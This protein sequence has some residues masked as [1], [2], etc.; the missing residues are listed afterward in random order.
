MQQL[1]TSLALYT[2][3]CLRVLRLYRLLLLHLYCV[4]Q[5]YSSLLYLAPPFF[6]GGFNGHRK[7]I[8]SAG[9]DR[10][11]INQLGFRTAKKNA[12]GQYRTGRKRG[13]GR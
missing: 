5:L 8:R 11:E 13:V 9:K 10:E 2:V 12:P 7:R 3:S 6:G 1:R 4:L